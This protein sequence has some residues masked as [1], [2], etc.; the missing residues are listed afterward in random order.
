M[1]CGADAQGRK[2]I[3]NMKKFFLLALLAIG[4][5]GP[6]W[7]N[8]YITVKDSPLN[9]VEIHYYNLN[10]KPIRRTAVYLSG[11][12]YVKVRSGTSELVSNDFAKRYTQETW[13]D[14]K[15]SRKSVSTEHLN[16]IFQNLVNH[17]LLDLEKNFQR[18]NKK[19]FTRFMAVRAN[20]NN[21]AYYMQENIYEVSPD[22]AEQL[23]DVVQEFK[24]YTY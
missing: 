20:I 2:G 11:S 4:G 23:F 22:L 19:E 21:S 9:W 17:G 6:F 5:C 12:G 3:R 13:E 24:D 7:I 10:R 16:D 18:S 8:P 15:W 1:P 14:I